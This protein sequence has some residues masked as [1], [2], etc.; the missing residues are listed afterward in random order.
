MDFYPSGGM[1]DLFGIYDTLALARVHAGLKK[2][3]REGGEWHAVDPERGLL[4]VGKNLEHKRPIE[5]LSLSD[6]Q[7]AAI[8]GWF[9][10]FS[11]S[12]H[13]EPDSEEELTKAG[14]RVRDELL[15]LGVGYESLRSEHGW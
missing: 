2:S 4:W 3:N 7:R 14:L 5:W 10:L 9:Y 8:E 15:L 12:A 6:E 1:A 11:H 13:N